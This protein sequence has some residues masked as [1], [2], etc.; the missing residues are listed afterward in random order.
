V[1]F[2]V[3][4]I[5]SATDIQIAHKCALGP[6]MCMSVNDSSQDFVENNSRIQLTITVK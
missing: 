6:S 5:L 2:Q 4:I 1:E 3:Y